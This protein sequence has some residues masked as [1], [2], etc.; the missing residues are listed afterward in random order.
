MENI[1]LPEEFVKYSNEEYS[2][3]ADEQVGFRDGAQAVLTS[4]DK[5]LRGKRALLVQEHILANDGIKT[6]SKKAL[7]YSNQVVFIDNLLTQ[8]TTLKP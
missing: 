7:K 8:L 3:N 6:V 4:V 2:D 5:M 1:T